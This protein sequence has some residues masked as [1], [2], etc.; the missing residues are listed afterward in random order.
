MWEGLWS[1]ARYNLHLSDEEFGELT[2]RQFK[3]LMQRFEQEQ[4]HKNWYNACLCTSIINT[5]MYRPKK[6][7]KISDF[8]PTSSPT[9]SEPVKRVKRVTKANRKAVADSLRA[10]FTAARPLD[11]R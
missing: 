5:S 2:P 11:K 9:S 6:P 8:M 1:Q 3:S 10:M 7:V 4:E